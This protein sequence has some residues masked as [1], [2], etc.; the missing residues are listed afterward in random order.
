MT[1]NILHRGYTFLFLACM[2]LAS[3]HTLGRSKYKFDTGMNRVAFKGYNVTLSTFRYDTI[4]TKHQVTG[5]TLM[6]ILEIF[7]YPIALN[8]H[9][10][11]D[12]KTNNPLQFRGKEPNQRTALMMAMK[13][14]LQTLEDGLYI[15]DV[16][17]I[18]VDTNGKIASFWYKGL[19]KSA[20]IDDTTKPKMN[21]PLQQ[22]VLDILAATLQK[23]PGYIPVRENDKPVIVNINA[24]EYWR[25]FKVERHIVY[26]MNNMGTWLP[27]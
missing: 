6:R 20:V 8:N 19:R 9:E 27:I 3:Q 13:P 18:I 24:S 17:N 7:P 26:E 5:E 4:Y 14:T 21:L 12:Y 23:S 10:I 11:L 25:Q 22:K 16:S 1:L 2:V 15:L